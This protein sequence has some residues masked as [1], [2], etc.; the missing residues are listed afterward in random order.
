M[1]SRLIHPL[2]G[3]AAAVTLATLLVWSLSSFPPTLSLGVLYVFAVLPVAVLC[4]IRWALAVAV[5]SMLAFNFFFLPPVHTFALNDSENWF[6]LTAYSVTA[7]V[8]GEL[9]ARA[10]RRAADAEQRQREAS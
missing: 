4:G 1:R 7:L 2:L 3:S 8:V 6:A 9:A 10:R 5:A